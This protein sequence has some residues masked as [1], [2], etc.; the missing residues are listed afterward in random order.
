MEGRY[1]AFMTC[2]ASS[3]LP[4]SRALRALSRAS[5]TVL[6]MPAIFSSMTLSAGVK[7]APSIFFCNSDI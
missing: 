1:C 2:T 7:D 4:S 3:A 6:R 5:I